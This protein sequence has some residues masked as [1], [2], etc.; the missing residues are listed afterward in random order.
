MLSKRIAVLGAGPV[1][2]EVALALRERGHDVHVYE[3]DRVGGNVS[4][5]GHV[6][7]FSPWKMNRSERGLRLLDAAG[8][9]LPEDD[10]Y[11]TGTE[12]VERYLVPLA[13]SAPLAGR[14]HEGHEVLFVGRDGIGKNELIGGPR[15]RHPFRLLVESG[16]RE[17]V[18]EADVVV[19][20]TGTYG[21]PAFMGNGNLPARGERR[22][23][24]R[25][26]YELPDVSGAGRDRFEGRNVLVV[27]GGHSAATALDG[28]LGLRGTTVHWVVRKDGPE[29]VIENDPLP[30][31]ARLSEL[32]KALSAGSNPRVHF[33]PRASVESIGEIERRFEVEI[34]AGGMS[35]RIL[36]DEILAHVGSVPDNSLYRELQVHECYASSAPM[37]LAAALLGESSADCLAQ[38]SKGPATLLN[39]EPDF[40]ILGMKSYGRSSRFLVRVGL[41]QVEELATL[42]ED[43]ARK[44]KAS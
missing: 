19:D 7:L 2:L 5:W 3:R 42:I 29:P 24:S 28:L 41:Q 38:T 15:H 44:E 16:G 23:R 12:H 40:F 31:R 27:G 22:L 4:R 21:N 36:V 18:V 1:G 13:R 39:P 8:A 17:S 14:I 9:N 11:L 26:H 10:D 32:A 37:K 20:C 6:R 35:K 33:H 25:I 43:R 34:R 30:E